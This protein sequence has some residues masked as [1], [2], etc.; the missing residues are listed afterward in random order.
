MHVDLAA[1]RPP[2]QVRGA[3]RGSPVDVSGEGEPHHA[4]TCVIE[5]DFRILDRCITG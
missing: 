3:P 2:P 5:G 1:T 4:V